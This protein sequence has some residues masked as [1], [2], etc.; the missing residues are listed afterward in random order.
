MTSIFY[1][2]YPKVLEIYVRLDTDGAG[3]HNPIWSDDFKTWAFK[4]INFKE[5]KFIHAAWANNDR[6]VIAI[7]LDFACDEDAVAFKLKWL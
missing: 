3:R 7:T 1:I 5:I 6:S 2:P 4:N